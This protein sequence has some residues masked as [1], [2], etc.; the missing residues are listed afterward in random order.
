MKRR[1]LLSAFGAVLFFGLD[2]VHVRAG[3]WSATRAHGVP[4]WY[5]LVYFSG[6]FVAATLLRRFERRYQLAPGGNA[7]GFD[8]GMF[9]VLLVMHLLLFRTEVLL[10]AV[11]VVVLAAR[12][13]VFRRPGDLVLGLVIAL[14]DATVEWAMA[15]RGLF[16][17]SHARFALLPLWLL[18]FWAGLG[19]SLRGFFLVAESAAAP[20]PVPRAAGMHA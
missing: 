8:L 9:A 19:V 18:P 14:L 12:L 15:S 5:V 2:S 20:P 4:W 1:I 7:L 17:Y 11:S 3:I 10:A 16:A 6:I 13:I